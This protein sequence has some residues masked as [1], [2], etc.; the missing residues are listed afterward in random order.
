MIKGVSKS[1]KQAYTLAVAVM[2]VLL[3]FF[4]WRMGWLDSWEAKNWDWRVRMMA[5]KGRATDDICLIL[6]DQNSLDWGKDVN[7]WPWPWMCSLR[8][9]PAMEQKT[10]L[11]WARPWL[12]LKKSAEH[13][14]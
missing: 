1:E 4:L 12:S 9:R 13:C 2:G 10:T 14:F 3:A 11:P 8:N 6:V 5:E 7:G